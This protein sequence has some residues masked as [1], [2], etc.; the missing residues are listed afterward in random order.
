[1]IRGGRIG[2]DRDPLPNP[3]KCCRFRP[4]IIPRAGVKVRR[5]CTTYASSESSVR[6][7]LPSASGIAATSWTIPS[8]P[9]GFTS[10]CR[11]SPHWL[12]GTRRKSGNTLSPRD[13]TTTGGHCLKFQGAFENALTRLM[14]APHLEDAIDLADHFGL[15]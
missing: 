8:W 6:W 4:L 13:W 3:G 9:S 2:A 10:V 1:M 14:L 11:T 12:L 7:T 15:A 5:V